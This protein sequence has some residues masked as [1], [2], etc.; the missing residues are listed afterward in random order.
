MRTAFAQMTKTDSGYT[1]K[2]PE[3][4]QREHSVPASVVAMDD[5]QIEI[6]AE[7]QLASTESERWNPDE[8][9]E[10]KEA[11]CQRLREVRDKYTTRTMKV[12]T[13]EMREWSIPTS[14]NG[15][16]WDSIRKVLEAADKAHEHLMSL[17]RSGVQFVGPLQLV[18]L[19]PPGPPTFG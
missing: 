1:I 13:L 15:I 7:M 14:A 6:M 5:G 3:A 19:I 10:R 9:A 2:Y 18:A 17:I 4:V 16:P 8:F 11:I 12:W